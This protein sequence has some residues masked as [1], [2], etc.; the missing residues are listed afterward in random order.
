M[1]LQDLPL[2][3][4]LQIWSYI[5]Q[6]LTIYPCECTVASAQCTRHQSDVF[7]YE[8]PAYQH[9]DNRILRVSQQVFTEVQPLVQQAERQ[10][11]F[12]L[13]NNLCLDSFFRSINERD[14]KWIKN[15]RVDLFVGIGTAGQ[16]DWFLSQSRGWAKRYAL[17][18]LVKY[19]QGRS[20][21]V[22]P[23]K[24]IE[25]DETGRRTLTVDIRLT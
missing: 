6:P 12:V 24:Q 7:C 2:E 8:A 5:V 25:Q 10:R 13:C 21:V 14:W 19:D 23:S 20:I 22:E 11:V 9:C 17:G 3:I 18:V 16:D 4:R 15:L 1:T